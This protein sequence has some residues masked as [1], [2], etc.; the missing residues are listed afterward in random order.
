[1][2]HEAVHMSP[3]MLLT[4]QPVNTYPGVGWV[5]AFVQP[6]WL[7]PVYVPV[8]TPKSHLTSPAGGPQYPVKHVG[9]HTVPCGVEPE[10]QG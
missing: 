1:M 2:R 9:M 5:Y 8:N 4:P 10:R 7:H 3:C 6:Q